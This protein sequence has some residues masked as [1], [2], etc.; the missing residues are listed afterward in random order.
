MLHRVAVGGA[1]SLMLMFGALWLALPVGILL[2]VASALLGRWPCVGCP[3]ARAS[4]PST[5]AT[6]LPAVLWL[7]GIGAA[8]LRSSGELPVAA[9]GM[10]HV[11]RTLGWPMVS[12]ALLLSAPVARGVHAGM[13]QALHAPFVHTARLKGVPWHGIVLRHAMG[14]AVLCALRAS[15]RVGNSALGATLLVEHQFALPGLGAQ[16]VQGAQ[17]GD[18]VRV[19]GLGLQ[20]VLM[21]AMLGRLGEG[22]CAVLDPRLRHAGQ[23]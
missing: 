7:A 19:C 4:D 15:R 3:D 11:W 9:S 1:I 2:G 12:L 20:A 22:G 5:R 18:L 17:C 13:R 16:L 21:V 10:Q 14:P 6:A 8:L 23:Q